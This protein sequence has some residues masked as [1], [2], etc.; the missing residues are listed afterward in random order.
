MFYLYW[1]TLTK[2]NCQ[3]F[4]FIDKKSILTL[5]TTRQSNKCMILNFLLPKS[6]NMSA[7]FL[8]IIIE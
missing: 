3:I 1:K 8:S 6:T 7:V 2:K 4:I 5:N